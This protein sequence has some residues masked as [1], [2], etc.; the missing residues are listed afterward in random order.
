[1]GQ[2]G[3]PFLIRRVSCSGQNSE[4]Q[5]KSFLF[6]TAGKLRQET[7]LGCPVAQVAGCQTTERIDWA[8]DLLVQ[9]VGCIAGFAEFTD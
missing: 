2:T 1:M 9:R 3:Q 4:R 5:A 7:N 8:F 6:S